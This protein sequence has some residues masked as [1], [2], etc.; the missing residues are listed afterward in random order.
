LGE[1]LL[2]LWFVLTAAGQRESLAGEIQNPIPVV[3]D[4][5]ITVTKE[6]EESVE[7]EAAFDKKTVKLYPNE[8]VK[9]ALWIKGRLR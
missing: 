4:G 9:N 8:S 6:P 1:L 3:T 7:L 2:C 5:G